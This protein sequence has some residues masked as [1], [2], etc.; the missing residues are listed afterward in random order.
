MRSLFIFDT[1]FI[2][3]VMA[4]VGGVEQY[5]AKIDVVCPTRGRSANS[6]PISFCTFE[7]YLYLSW[8]TLTVFSN[9]M[10]QQYNMQLKQNMT[11]RKK[12]EGCGRTSSRAYYSPESRQRTG[13]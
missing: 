10:F 9:I 11:L 2:C 1:V 12:H 6:C 7:G 13:Q 4:V 8:V 5:W 3:L